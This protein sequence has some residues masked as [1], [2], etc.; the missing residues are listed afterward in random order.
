M[1]TITKKK[2][3]QKIENG[4]YP[5][6]LTGVKDVGIID[7]EMGPSFEWTFALD[8]A[9]VD[10]EMV[11]GVSINCLTSHKFSDHPKCKIGKILSAMEVNV[12]I[13]ENFTLESLLGKKCQIVVGE[14]KKGDMVFSTISDFFPLKK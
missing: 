9:K 11:E 6:T 5:G 3:G 7:P 2:I 13:D 4:V 1:T 10:G 8:S 14:K 12:E